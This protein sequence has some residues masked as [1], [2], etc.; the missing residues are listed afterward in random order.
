MGWRSGENPKT[1]AAH[2]K[3][4]TVSASN[5]EENSGGSAFDTDP[6]ETSEYRTLENILDSNLVT[7]AVK[8]ETQRV[9]EIQNELKDREFMVANVTSNGRSG[10]NTSK[11]ASAFANSTLVNWTGSEK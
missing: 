11:S 7:Y 1:N 10:P 8:P 4:S 6:F 5:D 9:A 2:E 3:S